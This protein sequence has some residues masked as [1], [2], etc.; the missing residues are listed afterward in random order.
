ML[1]NLQK[2]AESTVPVQKKKQKIIKMYKY[3]NRKY[4]PLVF[5]ESMASQ[6][7]FTDA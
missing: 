2:P 1:K 4:L 6:N 5:A 3:Q 7:S